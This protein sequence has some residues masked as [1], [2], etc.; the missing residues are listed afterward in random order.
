MATLI[1]KPTEACNSRC[2]YCEVVKKKTRGPK[3]MTFKTLELLF[4]RVNEF[5][6][7]RPQEDLEI[8]WHGGEPLLL[9]PRYFARALHYQEK[10][11][12]GTVS[13]IRHSIQSNLTLLSREF[14]DPMRKLGVT[15]IGTSYDPIGNT[16]GLGKN[17]DWKTYN[18]RFLDAICLLEDEGFTWGVIYVVTQRSLAKPLEIFNFLTNLSPKRGLMFNPVLVHGCG[19]DH[20][21][22][23]PNQY[24][25]F[26]GT[27]FPVWWRHRHEFGRIEP[28]FSLTENLVGDRKYL[29]CT[30]AGAC[31]DSHLAVL[32]D[33]SASLCGRSAD[34]GLLDYG[35]IHEK[36]FSQIFADPQREAL[37]RR[38]VVLPETACKGCRFWDICHGGCPLDGWFAGGS[39][40][41]KSEWCQ[42]KKGLI[43]KYLEPIIN[44]RIVRAEPYSA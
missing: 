43:E 37:R 16:R 4:R 34:C 18:Q 39:F 9:G 35:S 8:I 36:S 31:A 30:D 27:I 10:H 40:R 2:I 38:L 5:L 29:I 20:I 21:K 11:C 19:L 26:L 33:G 1:F 13:R 15:H 42:A 23:T 17:R 7:E 41:H 14:L 44:Q 22:I 28:F 25:E 3:H 12:S 32:P 6:L 24:A